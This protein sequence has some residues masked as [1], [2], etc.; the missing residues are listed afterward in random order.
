MTPATRETLLSNLVI[1]PSGCLLWTGAKNARGYGL[2]SIGRKRPLVHRLVYE[3]FAEPIPEGL[4]IDHLCRVHACANVSHLEVVTQ[5]VNIERGDL[6][7]PRAPLEACRK[8]HQFDESN[9]Y[10]AP[11]GRRQCRTCKRSSL[12]RWRALHGAKLPQ[13]QEGNSQ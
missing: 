7:A 5:Q 13:T 6:R 12:R 10:I 1:D 2:I 4:V 3:M 8:G 11:S 9:T